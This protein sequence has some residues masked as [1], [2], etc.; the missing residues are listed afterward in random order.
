M[1]RRALLVGITDYAPLA[2]DLVS[3]PADIAAWQH[4]LRSHYRFGTDEMRVLL[5]ERATKEA[6]V[7]RLVW[8]FADAE[9]GD[10]LLFIYRGHGGR[11]KRRNAQKH[12]LQDEAIVLYPMTERDPMDS[13]LFDD[14]LADLF[15]TLAVPDSAS[16]TLVLDCC[17]SAGV[18][19]LDATPGA[20]DYLPAQLDP[21]AATAVT[22]SRFAMRL[23][24][25]TSAAP[26][27]VI[28]AAA[29][30][31][32]A[33]EIMT[34]SGP[35]SLFSALAVAALC[36]RPSLTY[37]ELLQRIA[38][39]MKYASHQPMIRGNRARMQRPFTE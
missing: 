11:A 19:F 17:H 9:P 27:V 18:D 2:S 14:E 1:T 28:A 3:A 26:P 10:R 20:P 5:N 24:Q 37:C 29:A 36:E 23:E 34:P 31:E 12:A 21:V 22:M 32:V 6:V 7:D 30:G 13:A 25:C 15:D 16:A 4:L 35:R 8:L 39:Q 33:V 38:P